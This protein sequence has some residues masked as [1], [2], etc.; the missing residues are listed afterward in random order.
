MH[1]PHLLRAYSR[2]IE[3]LNKEWF[4]KSYNEGWNDA[5]DGWNDALESIKK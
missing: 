3:D 1:L 2:A 4:D 5:F